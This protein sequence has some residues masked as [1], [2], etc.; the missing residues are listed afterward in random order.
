VSDAHEHD[1]AVPDPPAAE[2]AAP[3]DDGAAAS[4]D[5]RPDPRLRPPDPAGTQP[6]WDPDALLPRQTPR[7]ATGRLWA[8]GAEGEEHA[9]DRETTAAAA[10]PAAP[11][12]A[13][14]DGGR[15]FAPYSGRFQFLLGALLAVAASAIVLLVAALVADDAG[16]GNTVTLH[17]GPAWSSWHPSGPPS[18]E[19]AQ[20][21]ADHVGQHYE[22]PNGQQLVGISATAMQY[23]DL[24]VTIAIQ[25]P[26]ARG[27]NVDFVDG[28]GVW[29]HMCDFKAAGK[30][31]CAIQ[32]G[33]PTPNRHMLLRR[34]ALELALYSFRYLGV[35]EV[36][37]SLPPAQKTDVTVKN[38][39]PQTGDPQ[40]LL[41][42][43]DQGDLQ[44]AI[45]HQLDATLSAQAPSLSTVSRWPDARAV[46]TLTESRVYN[47]RVQPGNAEPRAFLVLT[48]L[49]VR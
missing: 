31:N 37:V 39:Q 9:G 44:A 23:G 5:P 27:G 46:R 43:R 2:G 13:N 28:S 18:L 16:N 30:E 11:A 48:P 29:F 49:A 12:T 4:E 1:P 25:Q 42:R 7:A 19:S 21:I 22:L 36:V 41:F 34:E 32:Y 20:Q 10:D 24:P 33:K 15:R 17:S 14:D 40:A 45:D 47:F 35:N 3:D 38:G 26:A 6:T 8:P